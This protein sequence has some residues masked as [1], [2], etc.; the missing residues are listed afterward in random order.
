MA[1]ARADGRNLADFKAL[2]TAEK[3]LLE[4]SRAG[5]IAEVSGSRPEVKA[6][7]ITIRASFLRF[8]LLGG[9]HDNP[10][11]ERGP[12]LQGAWV[13]GALDLVG[14][15]TICGIDCKQCRFDGAAEFRDARVRGSVY[16]SGSCLPGISADRLV[17][18]GGMF[19][20]SNFVAEGEI[21]FHGATIEGGLNCTDAALNVA[22]ERALSA[23]GA[24][25]FGDVFLREKF[26]SSGE[27]SLYGAHIGGTLDLSAATLKVNSENAVTLDGAQ[28]NGDV[29]LR[30]GFCATATV[31]LLGTNVHGALDCTRAQLEPKNGEALKADR[32]RVDA[33]VSLPEIVVTNGT[34]SL[35]GSRLGGNL[36][37]S[38]S[39]LSRPGGIA[40]VLDGAQIE[41][42]LFLRDDFRADGTVRLLGAYVRGVI[43]CADAS[44]NPPAGGNS[45]A[46]DGAVIEG[47]MIFRRLKSAAM[48]VSLLN[49]QVGQ[50]ADDDEAWGQ[51][52]VIDG[53]RYGALTDGAPIDARSRVA[54]FDKQEK[55][56]SGLEP[57]VEKFRPQPWLQLQRVLRDMGHHEEAREVAIA[58]EKRLR[59]ANLIG[60]ASSIEHELLRDV[61]R[62][63]ALVLHWLYGELSDYGV[64]PLK[65]VWCSAIMWV[66]CAAW[67]SAAAS[68]AVFAPSNP[69]VFHDSAYFVCSPNHQDPDFK[70]RWQSSIEP[71]P[72]GGAGN[73]YL[74][75][76]LRGEYTTFSP[77]AY[78][79]D[80]LLPLVELQQ[81]KDW[82][83]IIPTPKANPVAE[84]FHVSVHHA[85][86][87]L[88]WLETLFGWVASLLLAAIVS[89]LAKRSE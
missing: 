87:W 11:H 40:L 71:T 30:E 44:L 69:L 86:R 14:V 24:R 35:L 80:V 66:G 19:C 33:D 84:L 23:D 43:D 42:D 15:S 77:L 65:L 16:F 32:A 3:L 57:T 51:E 29:L 64:R 49:A 50:L 60:Q 6:A 58:L 78:S 72:V 4:K 27:V 9:D 41:G 67:F 5:E 22:N 25:I 56:M 37:C 47:V 46:L 81:Q 79:L 45:L 48:R 75:D 82:A 13:A 20:D 62:S 70:R 1:T 74:C 36:D 68:L 34:V 85:V 17:V 39:N 7:D 2:S 10:V 88:I 76:A 61:Y 26:R 8:L 31:S 28:I 53:F 18:H 63:V 73:W 21:R 12:R 59:K 83:P 38:G 54:W 89:G 52:L 55:G